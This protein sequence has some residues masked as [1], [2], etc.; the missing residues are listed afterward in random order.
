MPDTIIL[1]DGTLF[2]CNGGDRGIAGGNPGGGAASNYFSNNALA[3]EIYNPRQPVGSRMSGMSIVYEFNNSV[4]V[5]YYHKVEQ[6]Q[7]KNNLQKLV[8][9]LQKYCNLLLGSSAFHWHGFCILF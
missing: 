8:W 9:H 3:G 5:L 4:L 2:F 1:P 7:Q 6:A